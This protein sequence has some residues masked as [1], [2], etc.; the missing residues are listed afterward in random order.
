MHLIL[1]VPHLFM[2]HTHTSKKYKRHT[3]N[4]YKL[5]HMISVFIYEKIKTFCLNI[6][7]NIQENKFYLFN[8]VRD[9]NTDLQCKK[10]K[11]ILKLL[12]F[13]DFLVK[14]F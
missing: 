11:L 6:L 14:F 7:N 13:T 9:K 8:G 3:L 1:C 12:L 5:N 4:K 2:S 10:M